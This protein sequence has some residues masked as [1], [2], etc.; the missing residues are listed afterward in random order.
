M[1]KHAALTL[2][3]ML[4]PLESHAVLIPL[5][6]VTRDTDTGL[7]W[8]D[9]TVTQGLSPSSV[10]ASGLFDQGWRYA[11]ATD[12]DSIGMRYIGSTEETFTHDALVPTL[13]VITLFG[14]TFTRAAAADVP[15]TVATLGFYDDGGSASRWG[16]AEFDVNLNG[17]DIQGLAL[18]SGRWSSFDDFLSDG[19]ITQVGSFL[20]RSPVAVPE[21]G[22]PALMLAGFIALLFARAQTRPRSHR[23]FS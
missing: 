18:F 5:G 19:P 9:V 1:N 6:D 2:L 7:E 17:P 12:I 22:T 13:A 14:P 4:T 3:L 16:L 10:A 8:L 20:V 23:T 21:P 15:A 11:T